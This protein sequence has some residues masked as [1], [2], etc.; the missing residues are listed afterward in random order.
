MSTAACAVQLGLLRRASHKNA[1]RRKIAE[2]AMD[3]DSRGTEGVGQL[4]LRRNAV[5]FRPSTIIDLGEDELLDALAKRTLIVR[6]AGQFQVVPVA[7][8]GQ[9]TF[10]HVLDISLP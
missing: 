4:S 7:C 2:C 1:G 9:N 5:A 6:P 10:T 3:G 8:C